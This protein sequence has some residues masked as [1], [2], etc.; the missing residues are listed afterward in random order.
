[1][2]TSL[3]YWI[4]AFICLITFIKLLTF[5]LEIF[6]KKV[7]Y[8][9]G[10][11][12]ELYTEKFNQLNN[13]WFKLDQNTK[14]KILKVKTMSERGE[15]GERDVAKNKLDMLLLKNNIKLNDIK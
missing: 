7:Y 13:N 3:T 15:Q 8:N 9:K 10:F 5:I 1:M 11:Y 6:N 14:D 12:D 4:V 2:Q